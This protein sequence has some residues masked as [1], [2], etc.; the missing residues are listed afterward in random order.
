MT[1]NASA[2]SLNPPVSVVVVIVVELS[3]HKKYVRVLSSHLEVFPFVSSAPICS[4]QVA[5]RMTWV[6]WSSGTACSL[7]FDLTWPM[8]AGSRPHVCVE[9]RQQPLVALWFR[10]IPLREEGMNWCFDSFDESVSTD[11]VGLSTRVSCELVRVSWRDL[12]HFQGW[13]FILQLLVASCRRHVT[14]LVIFFKLSS[15][16]ALECARL[17]IVIRAI[18]LL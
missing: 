6:A 13:K 4:G 2:P 9:V 10:R 14:F 17:Y 8:R 16:F 3:R 18:P 1:D 11:W 7:F 15:T 5:F 12:E